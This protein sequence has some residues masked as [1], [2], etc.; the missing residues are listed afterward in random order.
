MDPRFR[1]LAERKDRE[2]EMMSDIASDPEKIL[3]FL[4]GA[5]DGFD[6]APSTPV[7]DGVGH[8]V[9]WYCNFYREN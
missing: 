1:Q 8:F 6:Y 5:P 2:H 4:N 7:E 9:D 3:N